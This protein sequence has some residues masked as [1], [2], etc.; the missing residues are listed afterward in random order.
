MK[1]GNNKNKKEKSCKL[2]SE[3][4]EET[5]EGPSILSVSV[6]G[7]D[8]PGGTR[9]RTHHA[10]RPHPRLSRRCVSYGFERRRDGS[11]VSLH[12]LPYLQDDLDR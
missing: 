4:Q 2:K 8:C 12:L 9:A 6:I 7:R 1:K 10:T 11:T 5:E 3:R